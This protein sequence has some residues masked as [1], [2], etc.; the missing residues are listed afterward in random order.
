MSRACSS[1]LTTLIPVTA[2]MLPGSRASPAHFTQP[3]L[4]VP[5]TVSHS[6]ICG[7]EGTGA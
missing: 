4:W 6:L 1:S 7:F 3:C 5:V 2:G